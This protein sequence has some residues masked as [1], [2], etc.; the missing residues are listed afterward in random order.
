MS[1]SVNA[2]SIQV[3]EA[4]KKSTPAPGAAVP[5]SWTP[6]DDTELPF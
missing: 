3:V 5:D 4:F 6:I 1:L 2:Q